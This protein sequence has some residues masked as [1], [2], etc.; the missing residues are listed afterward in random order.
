MR[1][2]AI[3]SI[4]GL[5]GL[6][7]AL[8]I[9]LPASGLTEAFL[10]VAAPC[11]VG[12][13]M[14]DVSGGPSAIR[15]GAA[16]A[17]KNRQTLFSYKF[18]LVSLAI[19][20]LVAFSFFILLGKGLLTNTLLGANESSVTF[21]SLAAFGAVLWPIL[22]KSWSMTA[23]SIRME[24]RSGLL[25]SVLPTPHGIR[26]LPLAYFLSNMGTFLPIQA[27]LLAALVL[28]MPQDFAGL[29]RPLGMLTFLS[30]LSL[31]MA[32]MW[33]IGLL[34]AGL[35]ILH[36]QLGPVDQILKVFF[37]GL[38][39]VYV[40]IEVLPLWLQETSR[41]IPITTSF[42]YLRDAATV[43][44]A[45]APPI[46]LACITAVALLAVVAGHFAYIHYVERASDA[47][48]VQGY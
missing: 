9:F 34:F 20:G 22:W 48:R 12:I 41:A 45:L 42:V 28:L 24:Q 44:G 7:G 15:L 6:S 16:M 8:L 40:P 5:A 4:A 38:A 46:G 37:V 10:L 30:V 21:L 32:L 18:Q 11:A 13:A 26:S 17:R 27:A 23:D 31:S 19:Y 14:L 25:E 2:R 36:K 1:R 35:T 33:G 47:G 39:G 29:A 43:D 3:I